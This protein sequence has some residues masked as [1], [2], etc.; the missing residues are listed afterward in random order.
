MSIIFFLW[1]KNSE[2]NLGDSTAL[3]R[4]NEQLASEQTRPNAHRVAFWNVARDYTIMVIWSYFIWGKN[5]G[6]SRRVR[7]KTFLFDFSVLV[8]GRA[9]RNGGEYGRVQRHKCVPTS[10]K[11]AEIREIACRIK[12]VPPF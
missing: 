1:K 7:F 4:K 2:L 8:S 5:G 6:P 12:T 3:Q 9:S 11:R 10:Y